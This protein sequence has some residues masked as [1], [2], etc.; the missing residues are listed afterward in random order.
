MNDRFVD[1][2]SIDGIAPFML[3]GIL[4]RESY[5]GWEPVHVVPTMKTFM[6]QSFYTQSE[7]RRH[8]TG[9]QV[10]ALSVVFGRRNFYDG[11]T[12]GRDNQSTD[13]AHG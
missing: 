12:H 4:E 1:W 11:D 3:S 8:T 6:W 7:E 5:A 9:E 10:M 13:E 2:K